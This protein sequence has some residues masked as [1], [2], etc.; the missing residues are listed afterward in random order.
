V[1]RQAISPWFGGT[2]DPETFADQYA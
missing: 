2:F 1:A